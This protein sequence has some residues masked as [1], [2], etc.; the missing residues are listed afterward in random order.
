MLSLIWL[1]CACE[2]PV[3]RLIWS[4]PLQARLVGNWLC[5]QPCNVQERQ[6]SKNQIEDR[7]G[8]TFLAI[9][10]HVDIQRHVTDLLNQRDNTTNLDKRSQPTTRPPRPGDKKKWRSIRRRRLPCASPYLSSQPP[11]RSIPIFFTASSIVEIGSERTSTRS[12]VNP[13]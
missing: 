3:Y 8:G 6:W 10:H 4:T 1:T 12:S 9:D 5:T 13:E 7:Q 11:R 2:L